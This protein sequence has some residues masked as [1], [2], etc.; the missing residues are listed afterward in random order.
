MSPRVGDVL[1]EE[2]PRHGVG[3]NEVVGWL[4]QIVL[5]LLIVVFVLVQFWGRV[6]RDDV[7]S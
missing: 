7:V 3:L 2:T 1:C 4:I 6:Q 5:L